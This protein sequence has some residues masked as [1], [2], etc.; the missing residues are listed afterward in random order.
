MRLFLLTLFLG[1]SGGET[2]PDEP[3]GSP[4]EIGVTTK[5]TKKEGWFKTL[6]RQGPAPGLSATQCGDLSDGGPVKG[7]NCIT[8]EIKCG[9]TILGHT[10]GGSNN[11]KTEWYDNYFCWPET[12]NH[13]GGDERIYRFDPKA[14]GI[15]KKFWV[16]LWF[17]TPCEQHLDVTMFMSPDEDVCPASTVQNCEMQNPFKKGNKVRR[18]H[19]TLINAYE[20]PEVW[21]ILIEGADEAE[22]AFSLTLNC[23]GVK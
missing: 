11:F 16:N 4:A 14:N 1:C 2:S 12:R 5:P 7:P 19:R 9:E 21:Y 18:H 17:D 13:D 3:D 15:T 10:R 20:G 8:G 22:G 23:E 6:T